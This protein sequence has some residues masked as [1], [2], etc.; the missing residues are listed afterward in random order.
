MKKSEKLATVSAIPPISI[1]GDSIRKTISADKIASTLLDAMDAEVSKYSRETGQIIQPDWT[2]RINAAKTAAQLGYS[3][4]SEQ[5]I[6]SDIKDFM[7]VIVRC[8]SE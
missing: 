2:A 8:A 5:V 4:D 6:N 7:R 3:A 1:I